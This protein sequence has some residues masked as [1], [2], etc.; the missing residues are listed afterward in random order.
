MAKVWLM[1]LDPKNHNIQ[2][3]EA[4]VPRILN[5]DIDGIIEVPKVG[6]EATNAKFAEKDF[7]YL[8][9]KP[10]KDNKITIGGGIYAR[11]EKSGYKNSESLHLLKLKESYINKPLE[12]VYLSTIPFIPTSNEEDFTEG[13]YLIGEK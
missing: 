13:L 12:T 7:V 4:I 1:V 6:D 8:L 3:T 10:Y 2:K 9:F 11:L 5:K